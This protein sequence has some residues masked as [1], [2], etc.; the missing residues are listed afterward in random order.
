M[1]FVQLLLLRPTH[2]LAFLRSL[3]ITTITATNSVQNILSNKPLNCDDIQSLEDAR[4]EINRIRKVMENYELTQ[5]SAD[6]SKIA[7]G[8][9]NAI[10]E[11]EHINDYVKKIVPKSTD[12]REMILNA[13]KSNVLFEHNTEDEIK[14]IV[15]VFE[16]CSYNK[17]DVVIRQGD[18]GDDF[19]VVETGDLSITVR[20]ASEEDDANLTDESVNEVK[21]GTNYQA[22]SSFGELA[23][24]YGS[25]R[26]ATIKA[27]ESC[28][29]WRIKRGWYRGVI[30]QHRQRLHQ[31]KVEF[32]PKVKVDKKK[33]GDFLSKDQIDT[34]AQLLQQEYFKK[35]ET[36]IREGEAGNTFYIIQSGD[37]G[38]Y[39]K[40]LGDKP[41]ATLGKQK[42]FGEKALLSDDVRQATCVAAR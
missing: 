31:E 32:L 36:I 12:Q 16:P 42:F 24:I 19:F 4:R 37:V 41:I 5:A 27:E 35:G 7:K 34:M 9:R 11:E 20:I 39:K 1:C 15:D 21:V 17:G 13:I 33:F 40:Q 22:G 26:A 30:G 29:L 3:S 23:L 14:E 10:K 38:I 6:G 2:L 28:K 18:T 25:P 8:K